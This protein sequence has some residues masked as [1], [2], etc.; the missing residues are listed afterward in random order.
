MTY[1]MNAHIICQKIQNVDC[2]FDFVMDKIN[3]EDLNSDKESLCLYFIYLAWFTLKLGFFMSVLCI[4]T[5]VMG[6]C[7]LLCLSSHFKGLHYFGYNGC[8]TPL[9]KTNIL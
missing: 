7:N 4:F 1:P 2:N 5:Y 3:I 8:K 9:N 6:S